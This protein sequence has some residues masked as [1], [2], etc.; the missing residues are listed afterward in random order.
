[1]VDGDAVEP[2][3]ELPARQSLRGVAVDLEEDLLRRIAR[4]FAISQPARAEAHE[5]ILVALD[6]RREGIAVPAGDKRQELPVRVSCS[7][8]GYLRRHSTS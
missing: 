3:E 4:L 2:G 8:Q 7:R 5:A 6:E 1:M